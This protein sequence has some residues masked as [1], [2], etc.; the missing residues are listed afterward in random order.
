[1]KKNVFI[2][3]L[4]GVSILLS[5]CS[6]MNSVSAAS[7]ETSLSGNNLTENESKE[8]D[9]ASGSFYTTEI[10][11]S[12]DKYTWYIKNYAGKNLAS[13]GYTSIGGDRMDSYGSG[14]LKLVLVTDDGTYI[15]IEDEEKL[16]E[17]MVVSQ[18]PAPNSEI[19]YEYMTDEN[20]EEYDSLPVSQTYEEI[21]LTVKK[22]GGSD[23]NMTLT[24]ITG[25]PDRYTHHIRDYVGRNLASC[26]YI[27]LAG[28]LRDRYGDSNIAFV[29]N[30]DDG[31]YIDA[32]DK[33]TLKKYKVVSQNIAPDTELKL[34]YMKDENGQEYDSLIENQ[35]IEEIELYVT[36]I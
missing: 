35:N 28:D 6:S 25:S 16:K 21:V 36:L 32:S 20:G 34:E 31:S 5:G 19:K 4:L 18:S 12:P 26:G 13:F 7:S 24:D 30:T 14:Y 3:A 10:K 2:S 1:M 29:I 17:Y 15:D 9:R 11:S 23:N 33:E 22:V 27:S 8:A